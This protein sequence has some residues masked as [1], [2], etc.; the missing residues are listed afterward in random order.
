MNLSASR[1]DPLRRALFC[2]L[3]LAFLPACGSEASVF[4]GTDAGQG[5]AGGGGSG[6]SNPCSFRLKGDVVDRVDLNAHLRIVKSTTSSL[7]QPALAIDCLKDPLGSQQMGNLPGFAISPYTGPGAYVTNGMTPGSGSVIVGARTGG[8]AFRLL[9]GDGSSG[10]CGFSVTS[11]VMPMLGDRVDASFHC[12]G[13][14][15]ELVGQKYMVDV[16]DGVL[17]GVLEFIEP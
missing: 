4:P 16:S 3:V 15:T 10:S 17:G 8:P 5:G 11:P 9:G 6:A 13:L 12:E 1:N 7:G 2:A 14:T